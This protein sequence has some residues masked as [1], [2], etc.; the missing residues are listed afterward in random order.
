MLSLTAAL[1]LF[2]VQVY[3]QTSPY[4]SFLGKNMTNHS[5]LDLNQVETPE[6]GQCVQCH[7]DLSSCCKN[8]TIIFGDWYFPNGS[9]LQFTSDIYQ[10][11]GTQVIEL[12]RA[13]DSV[14]SPSGIYR[15]DIPTNAVHDDN[16]TSV[17][18]TV[19]VGLYATGGIGSPF[20]CVATCVK[21]FL[22]L[23]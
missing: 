15:C 1:V 4:I 17:R 11:Y 19:Y 8:S 16:N 21:L 20:S 23:N 6:R 2:V 7:T 9:R 14:V 12:C 18:D 3:S 10:V 5:L 22:S 13:K